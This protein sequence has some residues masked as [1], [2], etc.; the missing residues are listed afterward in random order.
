MVCDVRYSALIGSA[1][2]LTG[3]GYLNRRV[4]RPFVCAELNSGGVWQAS[5]ARMLDHSKVYRANLDLQDPDHLQIKEEQ[6]ELWTSLQ[7][8]PFHLK[9][10]ETDAARF[11]FTTVY[12]KSEDDEEKPLISQLHQQ[13]LQDRDVPTSSSAN[14]MAAETSRNPD[15]NHHQQTSDSSETEDSGDEDTELSD[16]GPETGEVNN[17]WNERRSSASDVKTVNKSFSCPECGKQF[18]HEWS[19]QK[20]MRV[21][22]HS[23]KRSSDYLVN[24]KSVSHEQHVDSCRKV[25]TQLKSF[26][27]DDCEKRFS[28]I[29]SLNIHMRVHTGQ[30]SF[31][32]EVC[33][34]R[35]RHKTNLNRHKIVHTGLKLFACEVCGQR[36]SQKA[37]L[38]IHM[39]VH[40]GQKPYVCELCGQRFSQKCSLISHV[41]VHT[42]QKP[43]VCEICGQRFSQKTHL[44]SHVR[45]HTGQ[46]PFACE[47]CGQRFSQKS[48]LNSHMRVHTGQK[49]FACELC[50]QNFCDK[51][52][53]NRHTRV[54]TGQRPFPCELCGQ[55]FSQKTH[56]NRHL[57]V[58]I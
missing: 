11:S 50:G 4:P 22:G 35:F 14:Q 20:H 45:V 27:C 39:R 25:Q 52:T 51:S 49:P 24:T 8:E 56:L 9:E 15:L 43:F 17:D 36:F 38:N 32:C 16:S 1:R 41:N 57:R 58:H 18:L 5:Q 53:L 26:S 31:V 7:G 55:R 10:E 19:L 12:I 47:L 21:T 44:N 34:Q 3:W 30:I 28:R 2:I 33:G 54:H 29:S 6:E 37:N 40:T 23:A 46:K 42:G 48:H 13:Q